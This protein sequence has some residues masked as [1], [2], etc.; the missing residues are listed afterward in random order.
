LGYPDEEV[1]CSDQ[2]K[3]PLVRHVAQEVYALFHSFLSNKLLG[4]LSLLSTAN[5]QASEVW[6]TIPKPAQRMN[7][8]ID[9]I[10]WS[11]EKDGADQRSGVF[12]QI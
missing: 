1:R 7:K 4:L 5:N 10:F 8:K 11:V 2:P 9:V 12:S 3:T 6:I